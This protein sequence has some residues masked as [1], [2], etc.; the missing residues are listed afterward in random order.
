MYV[1][2]GQVY[3]RYSILYNAVDIATK[4]ICFFLLDTSKL[5]KLLC[6]RNE[7]DEGFHF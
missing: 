1:R 6:E 4:C 2:N 7:K 3:R 5:M